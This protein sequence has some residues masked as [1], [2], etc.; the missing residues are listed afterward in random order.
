MAINGIANYSF[1]R[2]NGGSYGTTETFRVDFGG[3]SDV[4]ITAH[5]SASQGSGLNKAGIAAVYGEAPAGFGN[6]DGWTNATFV[7]SCTGFEAGLASSGE[8]GCTALY[9]VFFH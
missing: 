7:R 4:T 2:Y 8:G 1:G 6:V 5:L 3:A 9:T